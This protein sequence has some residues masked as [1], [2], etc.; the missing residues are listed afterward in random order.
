MS[1]SKVSKNFISFRQYIRTKDLSVNEQYLLELLFEFYNHSFGYAYPDLKTLMKA[2]NTTSKNR[3]IS[4]IKKLEKK[5]LITIVRKFKENN[6]Y[7]IANINEFI[8][9][10]NTVENKKTTENKKVPVKAPVDSN[11]NLPLEGQIDIEEVLKENE[12]QS[13]KVKLI[14]DKF[15]GIIL[16]KKQKEVIDNTE[17]GILENAIAS[18]TVDKI[19]ATYLLGAIERAKTKSK[20]L[21]D[22]INPF[23]FN[24]FKAREYDYDSLEK[25][26]LGWDKQEDVIEEEQLPLGIGWLGV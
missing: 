6:R 13:D 7:F 10:E 2:F 5:G 12:S 24:N 15:K 17:K 18:I 19:N 25:K 11:G 9:I 3:V 14:L 16:S 8:A 21:V 26:L 22:G 1:K 20:Y 4:T 23:K